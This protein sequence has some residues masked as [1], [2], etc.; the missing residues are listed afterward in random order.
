MEQRMKKIP[1]VPIIRLRHT[2]SKQDAKLAMAYLSDHPTPALKEIGEA[3]AKEYR[4]ALC[5]FC[6]E[7]AA[8]TLGVGDMRGICE[9]CKDETPQCLDCHHFATMELE[10]GRCR[11]CWTRHREQ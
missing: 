2:M 8:S 6:G 1:T 4:T 10:N 11:L 7:A 9:P 5:H 3:I